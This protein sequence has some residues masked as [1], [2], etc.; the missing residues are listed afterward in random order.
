[1]VLY[2]TGTGN[3]RFVAERIA[4]ALGE[5]AADISA[6]IK[7]NDTP[8]FPEGKTFVFVA[9]CYVSTTA[10]AMCD[11][12]K[13]SGFPKDIDAYYVITAA[14]YSGASSIENRRL[15][16]SKGFNYMGT[17]TVIMPQNYIVYFNTKSEE[18]C[19]KTVLEAIPEI[20][21]IGLAIKNKERLP[22]P[23]TFFGEGFVTDLVCAVY[24][25]FFMKTKKF[26][27]TDKCISCKKCVNDCPLGN[28]R[29][30]GS[31]PVWGNN[32]THCMACINGCPVSAIEY[33][34][35]TAD[36]HRYRGPV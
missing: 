24:Y 17:A 8:V 19:K 25:R 10:R 6:Y 12:I 2:F 30:E 15:S 32:C 3:S 1:M 27:V 7:S 4:D 5:R 22:D 35:H 26:K 31:V 21:R 36:R 29:F 9:P 18:D 20:D 13:K 14:S 23:K 33:G 16:R 34:N 11:F 28:I